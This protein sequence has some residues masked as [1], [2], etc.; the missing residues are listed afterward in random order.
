MPDLPGPNYPCD[1]VVTLTANPLPGYEFTGWSG[2]PTGTNNPESIVMD[3]PKSVTA[4]FVLI[5]GADLLVTKSVDVA[6]PNVGDPVAYTVTVTNTGPDAGTGIELTDALP[7]SL[8]FV[9]SDADV[10]SYSN[11]IWTVGSLANGATATL[12]I[13]ATVNASAAASTVTNTAFVSASIEVDPD[14]GNDSASVD[15]SVGDLVD[16]QLTKAVDNP[17]PNEGDTVVYTVTLSN[18]SAF[19]GTGISVTDALPSGVTYV[20]DTTTQGSY[21]AGTGLWTTG[22]VL[23]SAGATL[24][25]TATVDA[26]SAGSTV[27]N[28]CKR[29]RRPIR[30]TLTSGNN[31]VTAEITIPSIDLQ[32][33]KTVDDPLRN[34]GDT[35]TYT[36]TLVQSQYF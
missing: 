14:N 22:D 23:S 4:N 7:A 17:L 28:R 27:V 36:V 26:G 12:T 5:T 30:Q 10:G 11:D 35:V 1:E 20:S 33:A 18:G 13:N 3:G 25:V 6:N 19:D 15:F 24:T 21:V 9:S 32:I 29:F 2:D 8:N 16:L 34:E 31:S